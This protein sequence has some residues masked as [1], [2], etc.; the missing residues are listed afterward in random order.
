MKI[1]ANKIL[2]FITTLTFLLLAQM[3]MYFKIYGQVFNNYFSLEFSTVCLFLTPIFLFKKNKYSRIYC[4]TIFSLSMLVITLNMLLYYDHGDIFSFKYI[5]YLSEIS[6]SYNMH[7]VNVLYIILMILIL[8]SYFFIISKINKK[9]TEEGSYY[10]LGISNF[11]AVVFISLL[12]RIPINYQIINEHKSEKIYENMNVSEVISYLAFYGKKSSLEQYGLYN[13]SLA[14]ISNV[15]DRKVNVDSQITTIDDYFADENNRQDNDFSGLLKDMNVITIMIETGVRFGVNEYLT[16]NLYSL[17]SNGINFT[18][19]VSKNKT[20]NS[21]QI[22]ILGSTNG[23]S[24]KSDFEAPFSIANIFKEMDYTTSYFHNNDSSFYN[25]G[26]FIPNIGFENYYFL[27]DVNPELEVN[28]DGNFP[29]DSQFVDK[30][31]DKLIP[32]EGRFYSFYT[33]ITTHGPFNKGEDNMQ[34]FKEVGYYDQIEYA[35]ANDLFDFPYQG[36]DLEVINQIKNY[37]CEL[38]DLDLAISKI[39]QRLKDTNQ[40][41]NTLLVLYGDHE[42][43]YRSNGYDPLKNYIYDTDDITYPKQYETIMIFSNPL[44]N[45]QYYNKF[46]TN[47]FNEFTSPYI[48]VPTILDL[49]GVDYN[50]KMYLYDSVFNSNSNLDYI[51]YSHE[52]NSVFTNKLFSYDLVTA[53]YSDCDEEYQT[54]FFNKTIDLISKL[55]IFNSIYQTNYFSLEEKMIF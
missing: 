9:V 42:I 15:I 49:V 16:P 8:A 54:N 22:G 33:T 39:I 35:I 55:E 31:A 3:I 46:N 21:E 20:N 51:F 14:E 6:K 45:Q 24:L 12:I 28:F 2:I 5:L 26:E 32:D 25:R 1:L 27:E 38:M 36:D 7:N 52:L 17:Q 11:I 53:E 18:N 40:Y 13:H 50:P 19:N 30:I 4:G 37:L 44:L 10:K 41:D 29:L 23:V 48:I 43:Y 34:H 47:T